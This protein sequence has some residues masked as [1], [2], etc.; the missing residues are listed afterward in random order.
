LSGVDADFRGY[1]D[2]SEGASARIFS[3]H[4][5]WVPFDRPDRYF[6]LYHHRKF[7]EK[8]R[9]PASEDFFVSEAIR[10]NERSVSHSCGKKVYFDMELILEAS[11]HLP[12]AFSLLSLDTID[13]AGQTVAA[14]RQTLNLFLTT[15]RCP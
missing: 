4:L 13:L 6:P 9:G 14:N 11:T 3:R 1:A 2:I 8:F 10:F 5:L 15:Q 12:N 7:I